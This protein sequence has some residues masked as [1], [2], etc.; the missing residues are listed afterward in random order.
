[1]AVQD[2]MLFVGR[3]WQGVRQ[4]TEEELILELENRG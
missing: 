4:E 1:M 2:G 3:H